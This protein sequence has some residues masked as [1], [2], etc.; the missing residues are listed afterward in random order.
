M[1]YEILTDSLKLKYV[2]GLKKLDLCIKCAKVRY[3][4]NC[5]AHKH[6]AKNGFAKEEK[7]TKGKK[8]Q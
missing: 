2:Y 4:T 3:N 1:Q 6:K 5:D 7:V 8:E